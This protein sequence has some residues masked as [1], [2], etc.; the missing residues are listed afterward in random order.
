MLRLFTS[1]S[2]TRNSSII[3]EY[4]VGFV[5]IFAVSVCITD[6]L[7]CQYSV[8]FTN[9]SDESKKKIDCAR[10]RNADVEG[11]QRAE[12]KP[13]LL[14]SINSLVAIAV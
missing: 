6:V 12:V 5:F 9:K 7:L 14:T 2:R 10:H 3:F 13:S 1:G 4:Y 8:E 11:I